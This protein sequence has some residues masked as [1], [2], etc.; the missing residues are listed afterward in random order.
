VLLSA[1]SAGNL[2]DTVVNNTG[3]I[4]AR[5]IQDHEGTIL[6]LGDMRSG[7]VIV[8]G[9]LDASA[10]QGGD[11]GFIE[12]SA[13]T[14]RIA[15][16]ARVDT[17]AAGGGATGLWLIDPRDFTIGSANGDNI[18]GSTLSAQLVTTNV[19]ITTASNGNDPGDIF[20]NDAVSWS[21]SGA[22]TTLS[23]IAD[24]DVDINAPVTATNGNFSV[25]C[26]P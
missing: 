20:V 9:L 26:G 18:S 16:G 3:V 11:G 25:C 22:P 24:H 21:A 6:L 2:L 8:G 23:L 19:T 7:T 14:V 12:T 5:T 15:D 17:S 13:A 1:G 10:P 4:Q